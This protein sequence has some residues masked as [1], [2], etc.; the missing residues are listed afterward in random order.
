MAILTE[1]EDEA[2]A[3]E[4]ERQFQELESAST[5]AIRLEALT[6]SDRPE[7]E[8]SSDEM[9]EVPEKQKEAIERLTNRPFGDWFRSFLE[10]AINELCDETTA[11]NK[12]WRKWGDL[13]NRESRERVFSILTT[14]GLTGEVLVGSCAA[15][16]VVLSYF[17]MKTICKEY[18]KCP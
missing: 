11:I 13:N 3:Q 9:I 17:G 7:E 6:K 18:K 16:I 4:I 12:A 2:L 14:L 8:L 10:T 5:T 15:V 1:E